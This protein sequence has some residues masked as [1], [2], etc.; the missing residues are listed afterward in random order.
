MGNTRYG[1]RHVDLEDLERFTGM[2]HDGQPVYRTRVALG[3]LP[4]ATL[5]AVV[6]GISGIV[7]IVKTK[8]IARDTATDDTISIEG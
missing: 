1:D 2:F 5:K 4:N 6:H 3:G 8:A 7:K